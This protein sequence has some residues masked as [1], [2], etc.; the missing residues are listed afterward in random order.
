VFFGEALH[1]LRGVVRIAHVVV[2]HHRDHTDP[3]LLQVADVPRNAV[4]DRPNVG[5][6]ITSI[7]RKSMCANVR[8]KAAERTVTNSPYLAMLN[9]ERAAVL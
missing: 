7:G 9:W 5:A 2:G 8:G 6:V 1:L 4:G 3:A